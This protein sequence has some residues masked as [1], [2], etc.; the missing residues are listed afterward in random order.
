MSKRDIKEIGADMGDKKLLQQLRI[1]CEQNFRSIESELLPALYEEIEESEVWI[2]MHDGVKLFARVTKPKGEGKWPVILIRTPYKIV[3]FNDSIE[4]VPVFARR[5][6]SVVYNHVRGTGRSDGKW[7]PF[8]NEGKDGREVIDWIA[9]QEWCDGN[10]GTWGSSYSGYVQWSIA[11]YDYPMLKTMCISMYGPDPY[12]FLYRRGMFRQDIGTGW[13]ATMMG[14]NRY[15]IYGSE[16]EAALRRGAYEVYP[17][18]E[19]GEQLIGKPCEWYKEWVKN[20]TP[21]SDFWNHGFWQELRNVVNKINIPIFLHG[22]WYDITLRAQLNGWRSMPEKVREQCYF[23]IGP[24]NHILTPDGDIEYPNENKAGTHY[25]KASIEWFDA[26]LRGKKNPYPLGCIEAYNIGAGQWMEWH[27]DFLP[28][29]VLTLYFACSQEKEGE[30]LNTPLHEIRKTEYLYDPERPVLSRGGA[31]LFNI[32][33]PEFGLER[34][35]HQMPIG[36]RNDIISFLSERFVDELQIAGSIRVHLYVSSDVRATSFAVKIMEQYEDGKCV[37]IM[38]DITD[39]RFRDECT[40][41]RYCP[42]EIVELTMQL[43][44]IFWKLQKGSR[45]RVDVTSSNFPAYHIHPNT[46]ENWSGKVKKQ[47]ANQ[48]IYS[49]ERYPSRIE[50]PLVEK[51]QHG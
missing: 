15:Q 17:Q 6:Y 35:V 5:G 37:N 48:T 19:L 33:H 43:P 14:D 40:M 31:L 32:E 28:D 2:E 11:D 16:E 13:S 34:S 30:L 24:W 7:A 38:D 51:I 42:G 3:D 44:D 49:G 25:M 21:D 39:I 9:I 36:T 23:M 27:G 10:I 45:I 20:T 4:I 18:T 41:E 12:N 50:I 1:A 8:E 22:G 46:E 26:Y 29:S 47:I